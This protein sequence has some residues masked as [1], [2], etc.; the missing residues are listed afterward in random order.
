MS[1]DDVGCFGVSAGAVILTEEGVLFVVM[2]TF[3]VRG[4]RSSFV[5]LFVED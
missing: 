3:G 1:R 4:A 5:R 2:P